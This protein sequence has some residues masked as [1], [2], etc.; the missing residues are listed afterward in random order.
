MKKQVSGFAMLRGA[1]EPTAPAPGGQGPGPDFDDPKVARAMVEL[2]R[3]MEHL[4]ENNPKHMA[5]VMRKMKDAMPPGSLPKELDTAI[6]R[7]EAG[8]DPEK[9]EADMG[10]VLGDIM[11]G[12]E[13]EGTG[14]VGGSYS[15]DTDL[16]DY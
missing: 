5:Q 11:G 16:Y 4:D 8:E 9:I 3:D 7:L 13:E 12:S 1:K 15:R 14:G 2:E 10:D 6:K